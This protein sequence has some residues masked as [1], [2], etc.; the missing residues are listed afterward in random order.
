MTREDIRTGIIERLRQCRSNCS[1]SQKHVADFCGVSVN[2]VKNWEN[3][4]SVPDS[5]E[6]VLLS[7][8][9]HV[10]VDYLLNCSNTESIIIEGPSFEDKEFFKVFTDYIRYKRNSNSGI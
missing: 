7:R 2:T 9:F 1:L 3:G 4:H 5:V 6:A 10:K 8:L